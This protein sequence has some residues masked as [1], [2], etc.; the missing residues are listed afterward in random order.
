MWLPPLHSLH[1]RGS[2]CELH[3]SDE[4]ESPQDELVEADTPIIPKAMRAATHGDT[5]G[6]VELLLSHRTT[7]GVVSTSV[8][9]WRRK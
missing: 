6:F 1:L 4:D 9:Q 8:S 7:Y 3:E 5:S 2:E